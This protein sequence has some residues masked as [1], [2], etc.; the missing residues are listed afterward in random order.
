MKNKTNPLKH[1]RADFLGHLKRFYKVD[2]SPAGRRHVEFLQDVVECLP[3]DLR[4]VYWDLQLVALACTYLVDGGRIETLY[5]YGFSQNMVN[6][7]RL[8]TPC[9]PPDEA[10]D[11]PGHF[12][13]MLRLLRSR[14]S[15]TVRY[16][17]IAAARKRVQ[18]PGVDVPSE[19]ML[20]LFRGLAD[21]ELRFTKETPFFGQF[22]DFELGDRTY[23]DVRR[24]VC[25]RAFRFGPFLEMLVA[26]DWYPFVFDSETDL[27]WGRNRQGEGHNQLGFILRSALHMVLQTLNFCRWQPYADETQDVVWARAGWWHKI[28]KTSDWVG[29]LAENPV[30]EF[31]RHCPF[32]RFSAR[33][34]LDLLRWQPKFFD[35]C[36]LS[37]KRDPAFWA[38]VACLMP[39]RLD[40]AHWAR[41]SPAQWLNVLAFHP[42]LSG[43]APWTALEAEDGEEDFVDGWGMLLLWQPR[44]VRHCRVWA[45]LNDY[46]RARL[47]VMRPEFR[48]KLEKSG[49]LGRS[50]VAP[51]YAEVRAR[52]EQNNR[53]SSESD[54]STMCG[55]G[56]FEET[57]CRSLVWFGFRRPILYRYCLRRVAEELPLE[58][59]LHFTPSLCRR[60][61]KTVRERAWRMTQRKALRILFFT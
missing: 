33:D 49:P 28:T 27:V 22:A 29:V 21:G 35:L 30:P 42:E 23:E 12:R 5:R 53:Y 57:D 4:E 39:D 55:R 16:A 34:W 37:R 25:E 10:E 59:A 52:N 47:A 58:L 40:D 44:F 56:Y 1:I 8:L 43:R 19:E 38:D 24:D 13:Y 48:K 15:C 54:I 17:M 60:C 20:E 32:H 46:A 36:H 9:Y 14:I 18:R 26:A 45:K 2:S 11:G 51:F 61:P 31:V 41:L 7:V 3:G 6:A 50:L